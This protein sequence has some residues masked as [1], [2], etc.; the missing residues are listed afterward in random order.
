VF[1]AYRVPAVQVADQVECGL[2]VA[3]DRFEFQI[4]GVQSVLDE[5]KPALET[6]LLDGEQV[7]RKCPGVLGI[8]HP[9]ASV[10][11]SRWRPTSTLQSAHYSR[12]PRRTL[13]YLLASPIM[14]NLGGKGGRLPPR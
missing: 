10:T 4:E 3:L 8:E 11:A 1:D 14:L 9:P 5:L 6:L 12:R 13:V 2:E 7:G